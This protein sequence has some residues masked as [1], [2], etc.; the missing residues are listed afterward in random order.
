MDRFFVHT[1]LAC[2]VALCGAC[3]AARVEEAGSDPTPAAV[4]TPSPV[5]ETA[6]DDQATPADRHPGPRQSLTRIRP[7]AGQLF[8]VCHQDA[9]RIAAPTK[10]TVG[11]L[12][13]VV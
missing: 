13:E 8:T 2:C 12:R 11:K 5:A 10:K 7:S 6:S 4:V 3:T 9:P 1:S